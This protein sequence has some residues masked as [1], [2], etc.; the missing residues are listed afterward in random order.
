MLFALSYIV[1]TSV[2]VIAMVFTLVAFYHLDFLRWMV[3]Q[4]E[5]NV[6]GL[7]KELTMLVQSLHKCGLRL[8]QYA[9]EGLLILVNL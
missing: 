2:V 6:S 5:R 4:E 9:Q 8:L 7:L 3:I 1:A